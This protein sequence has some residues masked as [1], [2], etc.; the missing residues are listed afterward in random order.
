M[1]LDGFVHDRGPDP[2]GSV[3]RR[4]PDPGD[5]SLVLGTGMA[6]P[7]K[8]EFPSFSDDD[9]VNWIVYAEQFYDCQGIFDD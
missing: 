6:K 8:M 4:A 5:S 1:D 9:P 2:G 7:T 3:H